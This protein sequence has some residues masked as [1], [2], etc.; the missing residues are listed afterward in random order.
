MGDKSEIKKAEARSDEN[1]LGVECRCKE[2]KKM[3]LKEI[4]KTAIKDLFGKG[5]N[6]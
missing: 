1:T 3:S 6:S 5:K 2:S 4:L